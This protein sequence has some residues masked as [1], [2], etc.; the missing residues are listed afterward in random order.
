[1]QA[2]VPTRWRTDKDGEKG[3]DLFCFSRQC[4]A[5]VSARSG[6]ARKGALGVRACLSVWVLLFIRR[7]RHQSSKQETKPFQ[8][9]KK[10]PIHWSSA[11]GGPHRAAP[12]GAA[13]SEA[14]VLYSFFGLFWGGRARWRFGGPIVASMSEKCTLSTLACACACAVALHGKEK[15]SPIPHIPCEKRERKKQRRNT[16][17]RSNRIVGRV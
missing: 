17:A 7:D 2:A 14:C 1:M 13:G 6:Q 11:K 9:E 12:F 4:R 15:N 8:K 3:G 10:G 16:H 5:N